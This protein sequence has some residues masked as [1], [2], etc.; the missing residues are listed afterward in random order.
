[1]ETCFSG[2]NRCSG[3]SQRIA[4]VK[5]IPP[6]LHPGT[7]QHSSK[8]LHSI[9]VI[10][11]GGHPEADPNVPRDTFIHNIRKFFSFL[12]LS[13]YS[14]MAYEIIGICLSVWELYGI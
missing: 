11:P 7:N 12:S 13:P 2:K 1:M 14:S 10:S 4:F 6:R 3:L 9:L 5:G 8:F